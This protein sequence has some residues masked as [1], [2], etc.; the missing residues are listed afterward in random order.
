M[1][2]QPAAARARGTRHS[3]ACACSLAFPTMPSSRTEGFGSLGFFGQQAV[4]QTLAP[5]FYKE[6]NPIIRHTILRRRQ[7]LEEAGLLE[8]VAVEVH[9]DPERPGSAY[10]GVAIRRSRLADEHAFRS[11][12]PGGRGF[13]RRPAAAHQGSGIHEDAAAAAH[14]LQLRFRSNRLRRSCCERELLDDEDE[15]P[16]LL[17]NRSSS[18][19]PCR[20]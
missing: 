13:H 11:G 14:L 2:A 1:A 5:G 15:T 4:L 9:P 17:S 20:G 16:P 19:T 7:T 6:H 8:R 3:P 10:P 18:L 12:L